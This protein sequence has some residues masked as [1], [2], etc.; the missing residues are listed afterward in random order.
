MKCRLECSEC[1]DQSTCASWTRGTG[2]PTKRTYGVA[3]HTD[4]KD[5]LESNEHLQ[6]VD[7]LNVRKVRSKANKPAISFQE[8]DDLIHRRFQLRLNEVV[9]W[10]EECW[11]KPRPNNIKRPGDGRSQIVTQLEYSLLKLLSGACAS[12]K[13]SVQGTTPYKL[14]G[15]H[16]DHQRD[17]LFTPADGCRKNPVV[18][19]TEWAKCVL[20]CVRCHRQGVKPHWEKE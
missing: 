10:G 7:E 16:M 14:N 5:T 9:D 17:K 11:N 18:A 8:L 3:L 12:C 13:K 2:A 20:K 19:R 1:H 15:W 4:I 6:F